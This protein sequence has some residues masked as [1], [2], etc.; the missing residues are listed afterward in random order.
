MIRCG[1]PEREQPKEEEDFKPG[2]GTVV[3]AVAW[4]PIGPEFKPRWDTELIYMCIYMCIMYVY[5]YIY[6]YIDM[7]M[8]MYIYI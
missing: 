8:Y 2:V 5:I 7:Y 3:R 6:M 1:D 4:H